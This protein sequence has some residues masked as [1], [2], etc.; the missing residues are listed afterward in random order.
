M[1]VVLRWPKIKIFSNSVFI[2]GLIKLQTAS[3]S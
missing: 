3:L 2:Y 1:V